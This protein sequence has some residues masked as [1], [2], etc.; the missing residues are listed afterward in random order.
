MP[1]RVVKESIR[2]SRTI[3]QLTDFQF[4]IWMYLITYV[5]DYGRGSADPELLKGLVFPRRKGLSEAV[6]DKTLADLANS[7]CIY[8]YE[9]EG[10]SYFCFPNWGEHQRIQTKKSKYP[11]PVETNHSPKSTVGHRGSP[12]ESNPIRNQSESET[13]TNPKGAAF[14][15]PELQQA[16][17]G[18][19]NMRKSIK[20]PLTDRAL[21][22]VL[23]KL[24]RLSQ[25]AE[26]KERYKTECLNQSV[27]NNWAD[28]Y[29]LKE[30]ADDQTDT[31]SL[32]QME[33]A[34]R[35][36]L[37]EHRDTPFSERLTMNEFYETWGKEHA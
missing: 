8:L 18:F 30:F 32:D 35:A 27:L 31:T 12:P 13:E 10:E 37:D 11:E 19:V 33:Q 29:A 20:K 23:N 2:T 1:N 28:I 14:E 4:R 24:D 9:V 16:F 26:A 15:N 25:N 36:Y 17:D 21:T 6:I 7:G 3:N 5:D 34:Y 22:M